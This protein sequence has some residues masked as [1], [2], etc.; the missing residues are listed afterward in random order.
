MPPNGFPAAYLIDT[1]IE[2]VQPQKVIAA[3]CEKGFTSGPSMMLRVRDGVNYFEPSDFDR[4]NP[5]LPN[6]PTP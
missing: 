6:G 2:P 3:Y 1:T 5:Y 4:R